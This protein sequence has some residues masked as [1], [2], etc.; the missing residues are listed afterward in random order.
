[1]LLL[2]IQP[3]ETPDEATIRNAV[4]A[5]GK[6]DAETKGQIAIAAEATLDDPTATNAAAEVANAVAQTAATATKGNA[7]AQTGKAKEKPSA[8]EAKVLKRAETLRNKTG[9]NTIDEMSAHLKSLPSKEV[10]KFVKKL[11]VSWEEHDN[12]AIN[13]MRASIALRKAMFPGERRNREPK[14][15]WKPFTLAELEKLAKKHK[16]QYK[17]TSDERVTRMWVI[18]ALNDAGIQPPTK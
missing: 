2:V 13:R 18:K 5:L 6:L 7:I 10:I 14:S 15:A 17:K 1:M 3:G 16:L 4:K 9:L 11:G 12:Q 8:V